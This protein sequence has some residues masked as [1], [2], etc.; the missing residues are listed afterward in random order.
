MNFYKYFGVFGLG[1]V[2]GVGMMKYPKKEYMWYNDIEEEIDRELEY[3][4][5]LDSTLKKVNLQDKS[6]E[7]DKIIRR[8][9][10]KG[11]IS[12]SID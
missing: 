11:L 2:T 9:N 7:I 10:R 1:M 3:C 8:L 6:H 4:F 5:E 12:K